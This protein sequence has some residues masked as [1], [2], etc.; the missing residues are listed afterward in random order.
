M[1][2]DE[3]L[4]H[5]ARDAEVIAD[6]VEHADLDADVPSCPGWQLRD[7]ARHVFEVLSFWEMDLHTRPERPE[8]WQPPEVDDQA[9]AEALRSAR[10]R[11]DETVRSIS[12][13]TTIWTWTER[14]TAAFVPRRMAQEVAVH[15]WDA[16]SAAGGSQP[17]DAELAAD[18]IDE[19]FMLSRASA[20]GEGSERV[21]IT[22][23][24][25]GQSWVG[26][27]RDGVM[28]LQAGGGAADAALSGTASDLL[29]VLWRRLPMT[30]VD[31]SGETALAQR[32]LGR[33]DLT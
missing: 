25:L 3:Y 28:T 16:E 10:L 26:Q 7:L 19:Y 13:D 18:G 1:H 31:V 8:Q 22:T 15:R 6:I 5:L 33:A 9:L 32:M 11:L 20:I 14:D 24:D 30:D 27:T 4:A 17:I 21:Q 23:T 29:L 2:A 12:P